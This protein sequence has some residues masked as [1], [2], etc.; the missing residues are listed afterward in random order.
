MS[1]FNSVVLFGSFC[2][3]AS[4]ILFAI[5]A[6][7][8][9]YTYQLSPDAD[10]V[11]VLALRMMSALPFFLLIALFSKSPVRTTT[12]QDWS[13]L[14]LAGFIG[15]YLASILDFMGLMFISASL[16]R[17]I[18]FLYPTLTVLASAVIY[19][20]Q[21]S[22]RTWL[23]ILL[24]YGG[25][26]VV[27]LG[28]GWQ[29]LH[30]NNILLGSSLVFAGAIAYAMYLVMTPT[31]IRRFG[32]WRFT[33]LAMSVA[34]I[35]AI[36]HYLWVNPN[37]VQHLSSLPDTV[38]WYGVALG[39]FSTVLPA[40]LLMQGIAR[41]GSAQAALISAGGPILT[42]LLAVAFLGEHLNTIQ[43]FG[44]VLNITGVLMITLAPKKP[45]PPPA[46][47]SME[48]LA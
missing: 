36:G 1:R 17:I 9:K 46:A 12:A 32:S 44:C 26:V 30:A 3:L 24:S 13:L 43:W 4:A 10:A 28:E 11:T 47:P 15:Y 14:L 6:I 20:Q 38:I 40:T 27:V 22:F 2:V 37:P 18:L 8:I 21:I 42:L 29:A 16:E 35:A 45:D 34:C 33:G 5:K 39:F 31:L 25:T 7:L 41:I 23:A 48:N 19:K